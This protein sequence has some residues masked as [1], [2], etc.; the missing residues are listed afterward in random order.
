LEAAL[1][2]SQPFASTT[3]FSS[4]GAPRAYLLPHPPP[5][6]NFPLF[7]IFAPNS[8]NAC[9]R[10]FSSFIRCMTSPSDASSFRPFYVFFLSPFSAPIYFL[11]PFSFFLCLES[12]WA[13]GCSPSL[14]SLSVGC[15][16]NYYSFDF[17]EA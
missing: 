10:F 14:L 8:M 4:C 15:S 6:W 5:M 17:S 7:L 3:C 12:N 13:V 11:R 1:S 9:Q 16:L 2:H